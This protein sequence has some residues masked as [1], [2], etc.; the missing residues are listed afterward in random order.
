MTNRFRTS[1]T[2]ATFAALALI[3]SADVRAQTN[4]EPSPPPAPE[5]SAEVPPTE[6]TPDSASPAGPD[7][8]PAAVA[9]V[10]VVPA[11]APLSLAEAS[12]PA[13]ALPLAEARMGE[14]D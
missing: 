12:V 4:D 5:Q 1:G 7:A 3:F 11:L 14:Q 8:V 6:V 9:P 13:P 2:G 10:V